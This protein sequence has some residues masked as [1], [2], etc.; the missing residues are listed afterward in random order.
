MKPAAVAAQTGEMVTATGGIVTDN[1]KT[2]ITLIAIATAAV[3]GKATRPVN[4]IATVTVIITNQ[5]A[6]VIGIAIVTVIVTGIS[7]VIV[8]VTVNAI[9]IDTVTGTVNARAAGPL[10]TVIAN[11]MVTSKRSASPSGALAVLTPITR[12]T[13][14]ALPLGA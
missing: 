2:D 11:V 5:I 12:S 3:V 8:I 6:I 1:E 13:M 7:I 9:A 4:V 10:V 14:R